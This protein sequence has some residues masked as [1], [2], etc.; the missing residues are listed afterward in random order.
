MVQPR[1]D[2]DAGRGPY[3]AMP[4]PRPH[5]VAAWAWTALF[6]GV[7]LWEIFLR[8]DSRILAPATK[9]WLFPLLLI[10][11]VCVGGA[12]VRLVGAACGALFGRERAR[13][14]A[15]P[16]FAL[17]AGAVVGLEYA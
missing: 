4:R 14:L 2:R 12:L 17:A 6:A 7:A 8:L 16:A 15:R 10:A 3:R 9:L 11:F 1:T 13:A 5:G